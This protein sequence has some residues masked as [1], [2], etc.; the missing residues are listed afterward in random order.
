MFT[1]HPAGGQIGPDQSQT[2]NVDCIAETLGTVE[3]V[4]ML[5]CTPLK[6]VSWLRVIAE[7]CSMM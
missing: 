2:I 7:T 1:L 4:S 6:H 5:T 3:E